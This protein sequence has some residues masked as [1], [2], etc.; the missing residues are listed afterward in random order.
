[1]A[2][3]MKKICPLLLIIAIVFFSFVS[4]KSEEKTTENLVPSMSSMTTSGG[5]SYG[6][7][8]GCSQ[9]KYCTSGTNEGGGTYTSSF[10]VPLT[11]KEVQQGFTLNS[12]ITINSHSSNS[13][14][15]S[16]T[17]GVLQSGDCRDIFKLTITLQDDGTTVE[18]FTHQKELTWTGLRDFSFSNTVGENT[19]GVLTGMFSLYGIDAGYPVGYYGPQFSEP[20]LTI[21][22]QT[23]LIQQQEA[24]IITQNETVV[25]E[26][27]IQIAE[28]AVPITDAVTSSSPPPPP[29]T[30]TVDAPATDP[31][32]TT[33][34]GAPNDI[35]PPSAPETPTAPTIETQPSSEAETT[36]EA[37]AEAEIQAEVEANTETSSE[38]EQS[39]NNEPEPANN[40]NQPSNDTQVASN[41]PNTPKPVAKASKSTKTKV[42]MSPARA[43][44][45]VV[46]RIAP[47]QRYG[48]NAQTVTLVAMGMMSNAKGL[49]KSKGIPDSVNFFR[50]SKIPDGPS[51]V[52]YMQNYQ[53]FGISNGIHDA[54]VESQWSK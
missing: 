43:A 54:L 30:N 11:E 21:D 2:S 52:N 28:V 29:V 1:M 40:N 7:G 24:E 3:R 23:V 17:D 26:Q 45:T 5:T 22:Y 15:S 27:I 8:Y 14:L 47:S 12:G 39:T 18:T 34:V 4:A 19:Y 44:Q 13:R 6:T 33:D 36:T 49:L 35:A 46:S 51:M 48:A 42:R 41:T 32:P 16:C 38:T 50:T 53:V 10:N 9:G 31:A 37:S 25:Q 20:S